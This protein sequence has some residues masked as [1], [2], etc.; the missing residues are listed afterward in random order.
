[1]MDKAS[2]AVALVA[3]L[4]AAL[5][6]YHL[7]TAAGVNP[8]DSWRRAETKGDCLLYVYPN[9]TQRW[10]GVCHA[11]RLCAYTYHLLENGTL[12][13]SASCGP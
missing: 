6:V 4:V 9:G 1:M 2:V 5:Y 13:R 7:A 3:G 12:L 10:A 11:S 8:Q